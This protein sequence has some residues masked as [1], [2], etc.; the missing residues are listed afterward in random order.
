MTTLT[1]KPIE[2]LPT[3]FRQRPPTKLVGREEDRETYLWYITEDEY[4][5]LCKLFR[6]D[7]QET[8]LGGTKVLGQPSPCRG[9]GKYAEFIDWV[10]TALSREV[11][12]REFMFKAL[13]EHR[14][15]VEVKHD[16][17]CSQCGL[18]T[19]SAGDDRE[20]GKSDIY[21]AGPLDRS[22][23]TSSHGAEG[24]KTER[25]RKA[26]ASEPVTW[27]KWWLDNSGKCLVSAYGEKVPE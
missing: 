27:G 19:L 14:Q 16:V 26:G 15:G 11:H 3:S 2:F 22:T 21:Q 7:F 17:Y 23:Y 20:G 25:P 5:R 1:I 18:L 9:C 10:W 6:R 12:S 8:G 4:L 24:E 13:V